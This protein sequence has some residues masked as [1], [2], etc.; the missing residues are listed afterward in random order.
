[1]GKKTKITIGVVAGVAALVIGYYFYDKNNKAKAQKLIDEAKKLADEATKLAEEAI[2]PDY[3]APPIINQKPW[4]TGIKGIKN[5]NFD[6]TG[7]PTIAVAQEALA[8]SFNGNNGR[9]GDENSNC[10]GNA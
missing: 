2:S 3:V 10:C 9:I 7:L 4:A 8:S 6:P 5:I 1:M